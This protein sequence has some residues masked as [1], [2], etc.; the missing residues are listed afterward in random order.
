M[1]NDEL[2]VFQARVVASSK[3]ELIGITYEII[4]NYLETAKIS[5]RTEKI[6]EF[7]FNVKKARQVLNNLSSSLD[8][9]YELSN[10]LM[11]IYMFMTKSFSRAIAKKDSSEID[12]DIRMLNKLKDA[13]N[14]VAQQD[15][16]GS[17]MNNGE[18][19]YAGLTYGRNSLNEFVTR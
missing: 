14:Q 4:I 17:A 10:Q 19:V 8:F 18:I 5:Y 12:A 11:S 1:T 7:I 6:E 16:S 3:S 9:H 2:K 15:K 13:F